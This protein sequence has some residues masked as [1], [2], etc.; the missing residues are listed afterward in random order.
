M[1]KV[2]FHQFRGFMSEPVDVPGLQSMFCCSQ[3]YIVVDSF[4]YIYSMLAAGP[5]RDSAPRQGMQRRTVSED[6]IP[7]ALTRLFAFLR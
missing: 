7:G 3:S 5:Y 1:Q 6:R 4:C 2:S